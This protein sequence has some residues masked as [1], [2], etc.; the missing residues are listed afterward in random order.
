MSYF[1]RNSANHQMTSVMPRE[2]LEENI[3]VNSSEKSQLT[4][5]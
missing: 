4:V 5:C 1:L 3:D 2:K